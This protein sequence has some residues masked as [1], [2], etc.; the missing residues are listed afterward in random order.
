MCGFGSGRR[1][2]EVVVVDLSGVVEFANP[3]PAPNCSV[4]V[5]LF[6]DEPLALEWNNC[7][8]SGIS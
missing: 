2:S 6:L 1:S 7:W 3:K 5:L 4:A 8:L